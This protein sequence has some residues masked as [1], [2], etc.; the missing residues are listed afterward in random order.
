[1]T[2]KKIHEKMR[3]TKFDRYG[4]AYYTNHEKAKQTNLKNIGHESYLSIKE[5][6]QKGVEASKT[7]E[8]NRK[9][10]ETMRQKYGVDYYTETDEFKEASKAY[11][12]EHKEE[13]KEK[14]KATCLKEYGVEYAFQAK[15]VREKIA[16]TNLDKY[17]A[18]NI[19]ASE[20][21]KQKVKE[22]MLKR[23]GVDH[24]FKLQ[25]VQDKAQKNSH[26]PEA[27]AK[28]HENRDYREIARKTAETKKKNG[29]RSKLEIEF[30]KLCKKK[31][32]IY[33]EEYSDSRYP[34]PCDFY[35]PD[36][37]YFIEIHGSWVHGGHLY[38]EKIKMT[39]NF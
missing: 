2:I 4:D 19:W 12:E 34:F 29:N 15:E 3:K 28:M 33:V 10:K 36:L 5:I 31:D 17:G 22:T 37:D 20:Y 11:K 8:A 30:A 24:I 26:T 35:L 21:G 13:I 9:R 6:Y 14:S 25:S 32:I 7:P 18:E 16:Q 23:Y 38:N 27:M 1:M 39:K